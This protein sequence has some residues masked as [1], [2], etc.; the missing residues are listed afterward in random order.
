MQEHGDC[1]PG[2]FM[3]IVLR[4]GKGDTLFGGLFTLC[5]QGGGLREQRKAVENKREIEL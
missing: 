3:C 1:C 2:V 4:A 5:F